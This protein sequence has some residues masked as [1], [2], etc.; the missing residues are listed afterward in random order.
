VEAKKTYPSTHLRP[1]LSTPRQTSKSSAPS[2]LPRASSQ[3]SKIPHKYRKPP[4]ALTF[5]A[6]LLN[7]LASRLL[8]QAP[9]RAAV[10]THI[11]EPS[12]SPSPSSGNLGV[13]H[14]PA[15]VLRLIC[16]TSVDYLICLSSHNCSPSRLRYLSL[17]PLHTL[18]VSGPSHSMD[19]SH[20]G[21]TVFILH[22]AAVG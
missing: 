7:V 22:A 3:R 16:L 14:S 19:S 5:L 9:C 2:I 1:T 11:R 8:T 18:V 12:F 10:P 4:L 15:V 17:S 20:P 13:R 21:I 6:G